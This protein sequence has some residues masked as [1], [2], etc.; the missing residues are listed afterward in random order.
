MTMYKGLVRYDKSLVVS[1]PGLGPRSTGKQAHG[2]GPVG[3]KI[4]QG[5]IVRGRVSGLGGAPEPSPG[6]VEG[7][8]SPLD[9]GKGAQGR[10]VDKGQDLWCVQ[11]EELCHSG[12][13][14]L[15]SKRLREG[16]TP[17]V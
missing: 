4:P 12:E 8:V 9:K 11:L 14:L 7:S 6:V 1:K 5:I 16:D 17:G 10:V 3:L 15:L 2:R 13:G